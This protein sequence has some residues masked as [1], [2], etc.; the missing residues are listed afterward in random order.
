MSDIISREEFLSLAEVMTVTEMRLI[1]GKRFC[2]CGSQL[3]ASPEAGYLDCANKWC[4][5]M[6]RIDA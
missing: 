5:E 3:I 1:N 4:A 6:Y 2:V